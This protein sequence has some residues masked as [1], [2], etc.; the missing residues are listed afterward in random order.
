VILIFFEYRKDITVA[1]GNRVLRRQLDRRIVTP[2]I[3]AQ[4][5][6]KCTYCLARSPGSLFR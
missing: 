1:P 4:D 2:G 3:E 6:L 5:L